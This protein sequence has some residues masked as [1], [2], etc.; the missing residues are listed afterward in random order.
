MKVIIDEKVWNKW[1]NNVEGAYEGSDWIFSE[2]I[3]LVGGK[4]NPN[5]F[6]ITRVDEDGKETSIVTRVED[7]YRVLKMFMEMREN[8]FRE[9][10]NC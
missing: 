4:D 10:T 7:V 2:E 3:Y 1:A 6:A 5:L 9:N 8:Y